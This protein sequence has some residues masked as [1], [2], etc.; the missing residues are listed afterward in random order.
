MP[1]N[2]MLQQQEIEIPREVPV[3]TMSQT[4]LF[5]QAMMP[6]FIFEPRYR[7]MLEHVLETDRIFAVAA[8]DER[9]KDAEALETPYSIA[10][11]GV[12]RACKQNPNGTS[13]LILQGLA[14]V[15]FE[16][17]VCEEP[18]RRA[19]IHQLISQTDGSE[20]SL[21]SVKPTLLALI[22]AQMQ[23]GA[24]IPKE[25]LQFLSNIEDAESVLDLAVYT[26]CPDGRLKQ[27]LLETPGIL[28][29]FEKF[30]RALR[31]QIERLKTDR[32]LKGGLDDNDIG[33]N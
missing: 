25:V 9:Q 18:Y 8:L 23:L 20:K 22:Q 10:G 3:M 13:N 4:V 15:E 21:N 32:H 27:E 30:E 16:D 2:R 14:R 33:H 28:A 1:P 12:I 19:R 11:V 26:L 6:L 29:R 31:A 24:R 17:I 5:P 7:E